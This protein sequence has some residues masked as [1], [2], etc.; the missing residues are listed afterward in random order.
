MAFDSRYEYEQRN[1]WIGFM[2][3]SII[4]LGII[5]VILYFTVGLR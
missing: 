2:L 5:A 4:I 3:S 1:F